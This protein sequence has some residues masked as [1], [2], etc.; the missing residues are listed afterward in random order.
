VLRYSVMLVMLCAVATG[1]GKVDDGG[2]KGAMHDEKAQNGIPAA[3]VWSGQ[4]QTIDRAKGVEQT[5]MR[6]LQRQN[7]EIDTQSR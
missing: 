4:I 2:A 6:S 1:C 7:S 3:N 5:L